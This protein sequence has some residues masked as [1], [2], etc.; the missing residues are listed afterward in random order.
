MASFDDYTLS[1]DGVGVY[2]K[3]L[4][5]S[6]T[7]NSAVYAGQIVKISGADR[8]VAPAGVGDVAFGVAAYD[9]AA[10]EEV[11]VYPPG[12]M[13]YVIASGS[14][15]RGDLVGPTQSGAIGGFAVSLGTTAPSSQSVRPCGIAIDN[16]SA[17]GSG[18]IWL[19]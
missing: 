7:A 8:Q 6:M 12:S 14:I 18:R 13:V 17:W 1:V 3:G 11:S 2:A 19:I 5:I 16:I 4:P 10:G 15:T 9:A